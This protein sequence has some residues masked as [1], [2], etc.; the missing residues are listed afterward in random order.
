MCFDAGSDVAHIFRLHV[1]VLLAVLA[2]TQV[3]Q[4]VSK[5]I[6]VILF[7]VLLLTAVSEIF[8]SFLTIDL[9]LKHGFKLVEAVCYGQNLL[10][11]GFNFV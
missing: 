9:R 7:Y 1:T 8:L 2:E 11:S 3:I 4:I 10:F 5:W 6:F